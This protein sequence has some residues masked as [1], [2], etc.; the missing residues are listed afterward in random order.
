MG[1]GSGWKRGPPR[2]SAVLGRRTVVLVREVLAVD[3]G[4]EDVEADAEVGIDI[5]ETDDVDALRR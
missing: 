2:V 3:V 4:R 1:T 5:V